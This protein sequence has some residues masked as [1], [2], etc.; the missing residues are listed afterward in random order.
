MDR[1][2]ALADIDPRVNALVTDLIGR[3]AD[4]WTML[5]LEELTA[6]DKLRFTQI[7]RAIPAVSQKM[8]TQTL[9][10]M[11]RDGLVQ[12]TVHPVVPPRVDY[13]L[14]A[15]GGSLG[16][17]FCGVWE[18]AE[19]HLS[20]VDAARAAFDARADAEKLVG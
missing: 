3:V 17:A 10:Q 7:S 9:R 2:P 14:T 13:Q 16:C 1:T 20:Q 11:E 12:R 15:L 6:H 8:L 4:K 18:W 5:V 19:A